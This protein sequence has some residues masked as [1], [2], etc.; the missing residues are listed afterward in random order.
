MERALK[1]SSINEASPWT[2][3]YS[4]Q[5]EHELGSAPSYPK[6]LLYLPLSP[7]VLRSLFYKS[8]E[9]SAAS[10]APASLSLLPPA[11]QLTLMLFTL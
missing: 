2:S 6:Y 1:T 8:K 10:L 11:F 3:C 5:V 9:E 4:Y 7:V